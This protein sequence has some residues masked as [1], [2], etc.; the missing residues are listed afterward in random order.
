MALK[1]K[2]HPEGSKT[3]HI[4]IVMFPETRDGTLPETRPPS[5]HALAIQDYHQLQE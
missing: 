3:Y 4:V 2:R 1:Q 5:L